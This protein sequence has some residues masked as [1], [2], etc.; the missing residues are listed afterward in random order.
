MGVG[1]FI[2]ILFSALPIRAQTSGVE[3]KKLVQ[4][5]EEELSKALEG[6][7]KGFAREYLKEAERYCELGDFESAIGAVNKGLIL[8]PND[9][10]L[11]WVLARAY[12]GLG[13]YDTA[14]SIL[15]KV[16]RSNPKRRLPALDLLYQIH[17][18]RGDIRGQLDTLRQLY[19]ESHGEDKERCFSLLIDLLGERWQSWEVEDRIK[20]SLKC[21]RI[22]LLN[23][24]AEYV[25]RPTNGN[26]HKIASKIQEI[27]RSIQQIG[28]KGGYAPLDSLMSQLR[29]PLYFIS[30]GYKQIGREQLKELL[31]QQA[32]RE[33]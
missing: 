5:W 21:Q 24:V 2:C 20:E 16:I 8:S 17:L 10:E 25:K 3:L 1:A 29:R 31:T 23:A 9:S 22:E 6:P 11:L 13:R 15:E 18:K 32:S 4:E 14:E 33:E 12:F 27:E 26:F 30:I 19:E 28:Y 7:K